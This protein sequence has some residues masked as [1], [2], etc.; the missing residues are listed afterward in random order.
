MNRQ[1][2]NKDEHV[3][4]LRTRL[5]N[6]NKE[7]HDTKMRLRKRRRLNRFLKMYLMWKIGAMEH[8]M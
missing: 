5:V 3:T 6:K 2:T 4:K 1:M 7:L 8:Q